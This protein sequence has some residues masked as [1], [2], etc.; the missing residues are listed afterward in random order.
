[1]DDGYR[2]HRFPRDADGTFPDGE[3]IAWK[4]QACGVWVNEVDTPED[5][6]IDWR[7]A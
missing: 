2:P 1:M 6:A 7:A 4:C 3:V 5:C